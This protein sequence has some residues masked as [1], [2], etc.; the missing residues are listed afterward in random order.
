VSVSTLPGV[1]DL[2]ERLANFR[3]SLFRLETLQVYNGSGEDDA[4]AAFRAGQPIPVTPALREWCAR[5]RLRVDT[6]AAV[7]RVHVVIE[8]QTE[9]IRFELASYAPNVDAGEDVRIL[10]VRP[11]RAWP[12][13]V[14]DADFWLIDSRDLFSMAYETDGTWLGAQLTTDPKLLADACFGRDAALALAEP[15][16]SYMRRQS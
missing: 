9:Y 6:G 12:A 7:Q 4:F 13:D 1:S 11:G 2:R 14:P 8:P 10:P 3:Y 5:V 16:S 15:W